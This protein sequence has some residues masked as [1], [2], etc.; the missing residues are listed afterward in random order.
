MKTKLKILNALHKSVKENPEGYYYDSLPLYRTRLSALKK[1]LSRIR[2]GEQ[3]IAYRNLTE[4]IKDIDKAT[5]VAEVNSLVVYNYLRHYKDIENFID[6][7][8]DRK[9]LPTLKSLE[10]YSS[11]E[12]ID[13]AHTII[14]L[15][16]LNSGLDRVIFIEKLVFRMLG[17]I[18]ITSWLH[19]HRFTRDMVY[20]L[21]LD[22]VIVLIKKLRRKGK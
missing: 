9:Q 22:R 11:D 18:A 15:R 8:L 5:D 12:L 2:T 4:M 19:R 7:N 6:D 17:N 3:Y 20:V 16:K 10:G 14:S 1:R 13:M 21:L